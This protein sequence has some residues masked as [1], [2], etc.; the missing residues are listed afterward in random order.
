MSSGDNHYI[1]LSC[2]GSEVGISE[3]KSNFNDN[4]SNH[5]GSNVTVHLGVQVF[6]PVVHLS[7]SMYTIICMT[8]DVNRYLM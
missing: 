5:K 8:F 1:H 7:Y 6:I 4:S 3:N 2:T